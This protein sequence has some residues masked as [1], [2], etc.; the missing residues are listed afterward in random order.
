[1]RRLV[2]ALAA[3]PLFAGPSFAQMA[4]VTPDQIGEVFCIARLGNDDGIL[5]GVLDSELQG[6]IDTATAVSDKAARLH[7]DEKPPLG[8]GIPWSSF[9]DYAAE[10]S[11]GSVA[12]EGGTARVTIQYGFP[13]S[14]DADY[15]DTLLLAQVPHPYD[16]DT[17]IWRIDDILY[18]TSGTLREV[19]AETASQQ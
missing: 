7:P 1:M 15:A 4:T 11:V 9:P 18:T 16:V 6:M 19:L 17:K 14:R 13:E 5:T 12:V 2:L 8:D 3:L 10:C